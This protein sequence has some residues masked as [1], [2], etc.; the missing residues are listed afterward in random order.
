MLKILAPLKGEGTNT[1]NA[2][3][4][5]DLRKSVTPAEGIIADACDRAWNSYLCEISASVEGGESYGC[6]TV[7]DIDRCNARI[8]EG[9]VS[10]TGYA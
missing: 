4:N 3:G 7:G 1:F 2:V 6:N 8:L 9:F 10:D 5:S